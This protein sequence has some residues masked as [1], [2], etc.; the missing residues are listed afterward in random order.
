MRSKQQSALIFRSFI[1]RNTLH[2]TRAYISYIRP[3][4]EYASPVWSPPLHYLTDSIES[5]QRAYTKRLPGLQN[6]SYKE[7][8]TKL[9]IQSLKHRRLLSDLVVCYNIIHGLSALQIND[10]FKFSNTSRTRCH[11]LRLVT[12]LI[13]NNIRRN[14]FAHRIIKPWNALPTTIVNSHFTQ[15]FKRQISNLD[16]SLYLKYPCIPHNS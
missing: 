13:K 14:F 9:K 11:N 3:L 12:H 7:R 6:L 10:F 4:L 16:L 15:S 2:L 8:L 1:S 5:V